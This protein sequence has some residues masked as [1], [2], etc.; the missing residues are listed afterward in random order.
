MAEKY[1]PSFVAAK[2]YERTSSKGNPYLTGRWGGCRV[3]VLKTNDTDKDGNPIWEFRIS[4]A[5]PY[6]PQ[7]QDARHTPVISGPRKLLALEG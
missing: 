2:L 4:E 6:V 7:D 1:P 3:A 5:P